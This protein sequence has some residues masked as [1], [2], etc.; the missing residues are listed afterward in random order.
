MASVEVGSTEDL[1]ELIT[2]DT[3]NVTKGTGLAGVVA[4]IMLPLSTA[5]G[6]FDGKPTSIVIAAMAVAAVA[7][8]VVGY[9][10]VSDHRTRAK[11]TIE[12]KRLAA[13]AAKGD[14]PEPGPVGNGHEPDRM[15]RFST[16]PPG[17]LEYSETH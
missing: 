15:W 5:V 2:S 3:Y 16:N 6:W 1:R 12:S 14:E 13:Q 10:S 17:Q 9:V 8:V 4:A 7:L 11:L